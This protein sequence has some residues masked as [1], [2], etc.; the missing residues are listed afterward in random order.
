[1]KTERAQRLTKLVEADAAFYNSFD[2]ERKGLG[3]VFECP[4]HEDC[5][6]GVQF[7]NPI[8]GGDAEETGRPAWRRTGETIEKLTL[9]P[10]I[11][12]NGGATGCEW[13]GFI[14]NGMFEHCGDA[15]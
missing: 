13:H 15:R 9:S 1:M 5:N 4:I 3:L 14:K 7:S 11:R 12:V 2:G 10:S 8:G 6:I